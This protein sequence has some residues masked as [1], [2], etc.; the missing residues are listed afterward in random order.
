MCISRWMV[1]SVTNKDPKRFVLWHNKHKAGA[2]IGLE[3]TCL[4]FAHGLMMMPAR[5][6]SKSHATFDSTRL[7]FYTSGFALEDFSLNTER[8]F[9]NTVNDNIQLRWRTSYLA[10]Q[11]FRKNRIWKEWC[12][13]TL[14][15]AARLP[16]HT[17]SPCHL[18]VTLKVVPFWLYKC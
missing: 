7:H 5:V 15:E 10:K 1:N 6:C 13:H 3:I 9:A 4:L 17:S 2:L 16:Q 14:V 18:W 12:A 11:F 8:K